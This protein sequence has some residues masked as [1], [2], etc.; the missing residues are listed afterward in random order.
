MNSTH[1]VLPI[2]IV[3]V[4]GHNSSS[5]DSCWKYQPSEHD[6]DMVE[7]VFD[8]NIA[9]EL[10]DHFKELHYGA[11]SLT[12]TVTLCS[13]DHDPK[14][15]KYNRGSIWPLTV[16]VPTQEK[17]GFSTENMYPIPLSVK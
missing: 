16:T 10:S 5:L 14:N 1:T 17:N 9:L 13:D 15:K 6:P 12:I 7:R 8:T 4:L 3:D 2:I 11:P